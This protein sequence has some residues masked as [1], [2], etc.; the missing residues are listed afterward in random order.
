[1]NLRNPTQV[2]IGMSGKFHG[3]DYHVAG[4]AVLGEM[5]Y[6]RV[7]CWNE[8]YLEDASGNLE[9]LVF[10]ETNCGGQW[11]WFTMFDPASPMTAGEAAT[12]KEGDSVSLDGI[13]GRVTLVRQS[14]VYYAE[15]RTPEGVVL[16]SKADYFNAESRGETLVVSWT[17]EEV[18]F[19]RGRNMSFGEV[20]ASFNLRS[21][22]L[23]KYPAVVEYASLRYKW[24]G[25]AIALIGCLV[26]LIKLTGVQVARGNRSVHGLVDGPVRVGASVRLLGVGYQVE[27]EDEVKIDEVS[28]SS[29]RHEYWLRGDDSS[30]AM[31]V[32]DWTP[33]RKDA[34]LFKPVSVADSFSPTSAG[35]VRFGQAV[36]L[37]GPSLRVEQLFRATEL[38]H[39][40]AGDPAFDSSG[41]MFGFVASDGNSLVM[42]R[43]TED[44]IKILEG[45][46]VTLP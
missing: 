46:K 20:A 33:G 44:N 10:E 3:R 31:L 39:N 2:Q 28:W 35:N 11:R 34:V 16:G 24:I 9:T 7:Y 17:G 41:V 5:E 27:G 37:G 8:F 1:M 4:W 13:N 30:T 43:W 6:G 12:M 40:G 21:G 23:V 25:A 26:L 14:E 32:Y 42:A 22:E 15:G 19:Y 18:E 38:K 45:T 29:T 36:S